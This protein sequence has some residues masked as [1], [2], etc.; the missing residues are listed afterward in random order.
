MAYATRHSTAMRWLAGVLAFVALLA[1]GVVFFPWNSLRPYINNRVSAATGRLFEIRGD[2]DV[3]W[4]W[5]P[6]VVVHD[7][8]FANA[9]W[10]DMPTMARADAITFVVD[11]ASIWHHR[12]GLPEVTL[13]QG[14]LLLER[15]GDRANWQFGSAEGAPSSWPLEVERLQVEHGEVRFRD[16]PQQTDLTLWVTPGDAK[17]AGRAVNVAISGRYSGLMARVSAQAGSLLRLRDMQQPF[18]LHAEGKLG[19]TAFE[20]SG[21]VTDPAKLGGLNVNFSL[22][23]RSMAELYRILN[24]PLPPTPA[25]KLAGQLTH[26]NGLWQLRDFKGSVGRSDLA[27]DFKVDKGPARQFIQADLVSRR[28]DLKDL[29]GFVG[30]RNEQ[31]DK[32]TPPPGKVLPHAPFNFDKLRAAD[33]DVRFKGQQIITEQWPVDDMRAHLVVKDGKLSFEPLDF[34]VAGGSISSQ[35]ALD[36][37]ETTPAIKSDVTFKRVNLARLFPGLTPA[38]VNA[39]LIGG[40]MKLAGRGDSIAGMLGTANGQVTLLMSGGEVSKLLLR[41]A[42]LDVFNTLLVLM[43]GDKPV[44]IRCMVAD[45]GV[46]QGQ[47][48]LRTLVLDTDKQSVTGEGKVNLHD[49][50]LALRFRAQPKDASLVALRGPILVGGTFAQPAVRPELSQATGRLALS[51]VLAGVA[52]PLALLPLVELGGGKDSPC[53]E[54]MH[55]ANAHA[56]KPAAV[57]KKGR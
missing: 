13:N 19:D 40:R 16:L 34:G 22:A 4:A 43:T 47:G 44:P 52:G 56:V 32:T 18:P 10:S 28:L 35:I 5:R 1:A 36:A 51:A 38:K 31:G 50:Q 27:G 14:S 3:H 12:I 42:N 49:E 30:A 26:A 20:A 39:G 6:R 24:L 37:N 48:T 45:M 29:S 8:S 57:P 53:Q 55:E 11:P 46:T 54:M 17:A 23:G 25:Y 21:T 15:Q 7:L 2:I 9:P 33:M 41:L